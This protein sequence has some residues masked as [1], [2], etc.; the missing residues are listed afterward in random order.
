MWL[1]VRYP[2]TASRGI[3]T[4]RLAA[5]ACVVAAAL[6]AASLV[7][8]ALLLGRDFRAFLSAALTVMI[9]ALLTTLV[10]GIS[11]WS[12]WLRSLA[13][14]REITGH[15][16]IGQLALP[17]TPWMLALAGAVIIG[18][19]VMAARS[20]DCPRLIISTIGGSLLLAPYSAH[21]ESVVLLLPALALLRLDWR[22]V[23]IAYL[24]RGG[25]VTTFP[26]AI[27]VGLLALPK[28]VSG[29]SELS[30]RAS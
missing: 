19:M 16:A 6:I 7:P 11:I 25:A 27:V 29:N 17:P 12:D 5:G 23:P 2:R 21:Y 9:L 15:L 14:F 8:I 10:F 28:K 1:T 24:L 26:F 13:G 18:L 30:V 20:G 3:R 22:I 4:T